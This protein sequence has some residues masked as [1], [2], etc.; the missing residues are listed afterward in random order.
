MNSTCSDGDCRESACARE[1][2]RRHYAIYMRLG[3]IRPRTAEDRFWENVDRTD[4]CWLW[5]GRLHNNGYARFSVN[6]R[7][8]YVHRFAYEMSNGE[9]PNGMHIDHLC[10]VRHC[11]NPSHL[12]AVTQAENNRRAHKYAVRRYKDRCA[13][14]HRMAG[15][16]LVIGRKGER[17]CRECGR[18]SAREYQRRRRSAARATF[19][20]VTG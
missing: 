11:V 13:N 5:T 20:E 17:S 8:V 3:L 18:R 7:A 12:E 19:S 1:L 10:R 9:I 14:G 4:G 16:N 15:E 6:D 2:C